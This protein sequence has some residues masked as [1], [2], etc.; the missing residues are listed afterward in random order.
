MRAITVWKPESRA[1]SPSSSVLSGADGLSRA[2]AD[3][4]RRAIAGAG[5]AIRFDDFVAIAL[6]G[7]HG[8]YTRGG[9]R[10]GR[11]GD[12][13]TSPE[14]GP[15]FGAVIA[16]AL[17]AWW[18]ELGRPDPYIVVDAGAGP[19]TLARA[20]MAAQP[21]CAHALSYRAVE[22]SAAQRA[23]HPPTVTSLAAMPEQRL[24]GVIIANELL[25]NLP[26]RLFVNDGGW[27][28]AL[29]ASDGE[30][31]VERLV[32]VCEP[33]TCL[34]TSAAHGARVAVQEAARTLVE[35]ALKVIQRGRLIVI[36]YCTTTESM[37]G[38]PWRQWLRTYA[39]HARG[40]HYLSAV[41]EQDITV[42]VAIDQLP[43]PTHVTTQAEF[44]R[45]YGIEPLVEEGRTAWQQSAAQPDLAAMTMRS[46]VSEAAA[47]LDPKGLGA[48]S[49]VEWRR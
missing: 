24:T 29:V 15:L 10:A 28:E 45:A 47:L 23:A 5:G 12:F 14:V 46:R 9:G 39:S 38:R 18:E 16:R 26:F 3:H 21:R 31:F 8:F 49:V 13:L 17:D 20:V 4:V 42:E 34:P 25:D 40:A 6:Y 48:F 30:R 32:P 36:D 19:G 1:T 11:R 2:A 43:S 41:G 35:N 7:E 22:I 37:A 33:R 27:R 44:L